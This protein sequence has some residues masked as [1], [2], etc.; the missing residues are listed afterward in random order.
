MS[1]SLQSAWFKFGS[2]N[3]FL[4]NTI[5]SEEILMGPHGREYP[6]ES[7]EKHVAGIMGCD[8]YPACTN[9]YGNSDKYCSKI[10]A[11]R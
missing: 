11:A 7:T 6:D 10:Q 8:R 9:N 1:I 4:N 2:G 5:V 3:L